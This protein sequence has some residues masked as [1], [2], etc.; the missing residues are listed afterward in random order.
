[1]CYLC[2]WT[3]GLTKQLEGLTFTETEQ[4]ADNQVGVDA[5]E[6]LKQKEKE[7]E[8]QKKRKLKNSRRG[9]QSWKRNQVEQETKRFVIL[10]FSFLSDLTQLCC[11]T[12]TGCATVGHRRGGC[13]A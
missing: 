9:L 6:L 5:V 7:I 13:V 3:D 10:F 4:V 1:V 8:E 2:Y 12:V 11:T